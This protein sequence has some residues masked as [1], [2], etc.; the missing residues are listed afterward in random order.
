MRVWLAHKSGR[1][2]NN[3]NASNAT[4]E[5]TSSNLT[6][7]MRNIQQQQNQY[8]S[9]NLHISL[10]R[11]GFPFRLA[12]PPGYQMTPMPKRSLVSLYDLCAVCDV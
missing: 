2:N 8:C 6:P 7:G 10:E 4:V 9:F 1:S 12:M 11:L 3:I 5:H